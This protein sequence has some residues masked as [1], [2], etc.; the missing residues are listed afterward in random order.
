MTN[1][2]KQ[3]IGKT[4][5]VSRKVHGL[6]TTTILLEGTD[7]WSWEDDDNVVHTHDIPGMQYCP[8]LPFCLLSPQH[9]ARELQDNYPERRGTWLATYD[10]AFVLEWDQ[11][12]D[13]RTIPV[14]PDNSYVGFMQSVTGYNT[15]NKFISLCNLTLPAKA[16]CL[17]TYLI[18]HDDDSDDEKTVDLSIHDNMIPSTQAWRSDPLPFNIDEQTFSE[19]QTEASPN[20]PTEVPDIVKDEEVDQLN[21]AT[22]FV[23]PFSRFGCTHM[24]E[25]TDGED[26]LKAKKK[27]FEAVAETYGV[28]IRHYHGDN[29]RF[30]EKLFVDH[31]MNKGQTVRYCGVNAHFQNSIAERRIRDLQDKTQTMLVHTRHRWPDAITA[32]LWPYTLR[33]ANEVHK[34]APIRDG[35]YPLELFTGSGVRP[36]LKHLYHFGCPVY[37]LSEEQQAN[38]KGPKWS[39]R[40]RCGIY[41]GPSPRHGHSVALVLSLETGMVS[42][43]FHVAYDEFFETVKGHG[44]TLVSGLMPHKSLWQQKAGFINGTNVIEDQGPGVTFSPLSTR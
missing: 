7:R 2:K 10:D 43:Q 33:I 30:A 44:N 12:Q 36:T 37:I 27:A 4:K 34:A 28:F 8:T 19:P 35:L 18:P 41:L 16:C 25:S 24:Q 20:A 31:A 22:I 40:A 39:E 9:L 38:R 26:T 29:G 13:R 17:P 5:A 21:T 32:N 6:G 1:N 11:R 14:S 23:D 42:P 3:F 15:S